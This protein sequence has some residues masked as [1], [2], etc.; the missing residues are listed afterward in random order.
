M[1]K[2][3]KNTYLGKSV[4]IIL[5]FLIRR[6]SLITRK[7]ILKKRDKIKKITLKLK[8][9][10]DYNGLE[11]KGTFL[12]STQNGLYLLKNNKLYFLISGEYYG[13]SIYQNSLF[14]Y[15][16]LINHGRILKIYFRNDFNLETNAEILLDK[17]PHG[18]HQIDILDHFLYI[19]D[20]YNNGIIKY[21]I[22][23][24]KFEEY[25]PL[26]KLKIGRSSINY[27]HINSIYFFNENAFLI[28]H[29]ETLKTKRKSDIIVTDMNFNIIKT[30][31]TDSS[32]AHNIIVTESN[33]LHCDSIGLSLKDNGV[34]VFKDELLT[35]GLSMSEDLIVIG[36]SGIT[37]RILRPFAKGKLYFINRNYKLLNSVIFPASVTEI[38]RI[39]KID[40][41]LS[42]YASSVS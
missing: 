33:M 21:D 6:Y 1:T 11:I 25:Y 19:T 42:N 37:K 35:R 16:K 41:S 20:T 5:N 26:G 40:Y 8:L 9:V 23:S 36:G 29:N 38:R 24:E 39:D 18:C 7:I 32:N 2:F 4:K 10:E 28:A 15:E 17:V 13:I 30:I 27:G 12:V 34:P 14:V 31:R 22:N 3:I